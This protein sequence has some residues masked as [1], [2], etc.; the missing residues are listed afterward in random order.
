MDSV[1]VSRDSLLQGRREGVGR[2]GGVR[3]EGDKENRMARMHRQ[4]K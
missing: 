3:V 4:D 2:M 1:S